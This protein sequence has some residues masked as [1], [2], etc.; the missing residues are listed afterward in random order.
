MLA[1]FRQ[2]E[3]VA[4]RRPSISIGMMGTCVSRR[5]WQ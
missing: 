1:D 5:S 2:I 3:P 4:N